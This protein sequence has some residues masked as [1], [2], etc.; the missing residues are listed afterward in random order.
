M[1]QKLSVFIL[2]CSFSV[3]SYAQKGDIETIKQTL[4][5]YKQKIESLD[6]SDIAKLFITN[7]KVIEQ[8]KDE[9]TISNYL[10]HH[11]GPELKDFKSFKFSN[12]RCKSKW[13]FCIHHRK[14]Y[15]Y[16]YTQRR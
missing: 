9:G 1:K 11:L 6:T 7:S 15:L 14:L 8:G 13:Q 12:Y 16:Y 4:N 3:L 10:A 2:M 5:N